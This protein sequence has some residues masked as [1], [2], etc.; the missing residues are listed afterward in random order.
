MYAIVD[1]AGQ[2]FRVSKNEKL[3]VPKIPGDANQE[4]QLDKVLLI[5]DKGKITI[6]QP[7][8]DGA[9]VKAKILG[10]ERGKKIIVY[11]KKR[12]KGYEVKRGHRQDF[13][14]IMIKSIQTKSA[15]KKEDN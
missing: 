2:Q 14:S 5:G 8:I 13:T 7:L 1:I 9:V 15:S 3:L 10:P 11:K 6:G 12:R 4:V